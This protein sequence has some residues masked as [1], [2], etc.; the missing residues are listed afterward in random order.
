MAN[1]RAAVHQIVPEPYN[2]A[3]GPEKNRYSYYPLG[4]TSPP[5]GKGTGMP[6][7]ASYAKQERSALERTVER[8]VFAG[9]VSG[10]VLGVFAMIASG[11]FQGRGFFTPMYHAAFILDA[12]TLPRALDEAAA[13]ERFFFIREP[14][15]FGM[16]IH[17][18]VGG[19][20]GALFALV[21]R[22]LRFQGTRALAGGLLFGLAAMVLMSLVV[23]PQAGAISGAGQPIARM[24]TEIGWPTFVAH[25]AVFG[26][27]LGAWVY[28]RPQDIEI[29]EPGDVEE[30]RPVTA[31]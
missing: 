6:G 26:L 12:D 8:G 23:L 14:F 2:V 21:S 17:V 22:A 10:A 4:R 5:L 7:L 31:D 19:A 13:G 18:M 25:F 15:T 1:P 11:T 28:L 16:I 30:A 3:G 29:E 20:L 24:G 9:L 27:A